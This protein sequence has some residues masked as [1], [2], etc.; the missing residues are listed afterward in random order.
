MILK[1]QLD[2]KVNKINYSNL[3]Q[4]TKANKNQNYTQLQ[5]YSVARHCSTFAGEEGLRSGGAERGRLA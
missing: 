1:P 2:P 3:F 4:C 5:C